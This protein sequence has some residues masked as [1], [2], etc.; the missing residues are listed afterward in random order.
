MKLPR[1]VAGLLIDPSR[2]WDAIAAERTD[3]G[4]I[5]TRHVVPLAAIPALS[6]LA[7][8]AIVAGRALGTTAIV[9]AITAAAASYA[10]ALAIPYA[11]AVA[12]EHLTPRFKGDADAVSA[13][14]L[15]A[16]SLTPVW[17]AGVFYIFFEFSRLVVFGVLY[18]LYLFFTG[19][20][21]VASV[22]L[23]QRVPFTLV[24]AIIIVVIQILLGWVAMQVRI[25]YFGM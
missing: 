19:A 24:A 1:R 3:I 18:A 20:T 9:T 6:I 8:L 23:E 16:Y 21:P 5:Y 7:G 22:P 17:L 4:E 11:A 12:I 10:M 25:P 2:E 15:V 14:K 13:F